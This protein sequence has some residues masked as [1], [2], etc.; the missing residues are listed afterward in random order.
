MKRINIYKIFDER[1]YFLLIVLI[2][3]FI[4]DNLYIFVG[5]NTNLASSFYED[6]QLPRIVRKTTF[7]IK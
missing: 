4:D 5:Y 6:Y 7:L 1:S 3:L 2:Y